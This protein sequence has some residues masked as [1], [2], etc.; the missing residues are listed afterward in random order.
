VNILSPRHVTSTDHVPFHEL[1]VPAF[2]FVQDRYEYNSRTHHSNMDFYDRLQPD[3]LKQVATV[4][5]VFVWHAA[6]R[7][8]QLPRASAAAG[9]P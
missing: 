5:A 9:V 7:D 1:G 6:T 3:D 4:A 2:Q 8:A